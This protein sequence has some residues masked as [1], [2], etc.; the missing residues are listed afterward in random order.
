MCYGKKHSEKMKKYWESAEG[1]K[2]IAKI[3][4]A[5]AKQKAKDSRGKSLTKEAAATS[6]LKYCS[7]GLPIHTEH[8]LCEAC[9]EGE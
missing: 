6:T 3:K 2:E 1:K 8:N 7:C 4:R 9:R 5:V